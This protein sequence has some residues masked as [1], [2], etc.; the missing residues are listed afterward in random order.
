MTKKTVAICLAAIALAVSL[1]TLMKPAATT[2]ANTLPEKPSPQQRK[3]IV[4][5]DWVMFDLLFRDINLRRRTSEKAEASG[6][7]RAATA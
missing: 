2:N 7:H 6:D 1:F 5:P 3:T 4:V